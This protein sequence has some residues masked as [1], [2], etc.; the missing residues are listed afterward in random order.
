M[1]ANI[2]GSKSGNWLMAPN[3]ADVKTV[4]IKMTADR[5][6]MTGFIFPSPIFC[7]QTFCSE[8][9]SPIIYTAF[10]EKMLN[11]KNRTTVYEVRSSS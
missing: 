5:V 2:V 9:L 7:A 1:P 4:R 8:R 10:S 3:V 6:D 11:K